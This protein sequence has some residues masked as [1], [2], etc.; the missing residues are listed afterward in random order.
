MSVA[1]VVSKRTDVYL[2]KA[3]AMYMFLQF[4]KE[5]TPDLIK[6]F[7]QNDRLEDVTVKGLINVRDG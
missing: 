1:V 4:Y 6:D 5:F 7:Y 3:F 2:A